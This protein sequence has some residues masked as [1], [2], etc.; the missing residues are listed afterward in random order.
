MLRFLTVACAAATLFIAGCGGGGG[1]TSPGGGSA[2]SGGTPP[3]A[4]AMTQQTCASLATKELQNNPASVTTKWIADGVQKVSSS[5]TSFLPA[6][7]VID[8]TI[9]PRIGVAGVPYGIRF[10]VR[11]PASWNGRFFF[12]GNG[13]FAG[14]LGNVYGTISS[15]NGNNIANT[16]LAQGF[17]VASTDGGH[18]NSKLANGV[19]FGL[20]PQA[21]I[22]YGYNAW[23]KTAVTAKS[24]I[25]AAYG[26]APAKSYFVGCSDGGREGLIFAQRFPT[27]FDGIVG[28]SPVMN[29]GG[30]AVSATFDLQTFK[31]ISPI[32]T[33]GKV[34]QYNSFSASDQA[35]FNTAYMAK[36]DAS[37]GVVDG[38]VQNPLACHF[39][40]SSLQ[41]PGEKT[42]SCLS[43]AQVSAIKAVVNGATTSS[44]DHVTI[45]GY[46]TTHETAVEGYPLDPSWMTSTGQAG[47]LIGTASNPPGPTLGTTALP[48][49]HL[50]PP[51]PDLD[52]MTANWDVIPDQ[53]LVNPPWLATNPDL[54]AFKAHGG[55]LM[56][57]NGTGDPGPQYVNTI[58]YFNQVATL[59]GGVTETKQFFRAFMIPGMAHCSGG[60]S[61]DSF[62]VLAAIMNWVE[63]GQAP[64][65]IVATARAN[66]S[67]LNSV[68][69]PIPAG[70]TRPLCSYPLSA[71]YNGTGD[72]NSASSFSCK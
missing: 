70:R 65:A 25:V 63:K 58:N 4:L 72:I 41:C 8:G 45:P 54:S 10:E 35:L 22:D 59:N 33:D 16:A 1:G 46:L 49:L 51:Q 32:G 18:D 24:A 19:A 31:A 21:D 68:S 55:K 56:L 15:A 20:D 28:G 61:T 62:D 13:G 17:A 11:L 57:Y 39:D 29:L 38:M 52:P 53:M 12:Q 36:C 23:D 5:D 3:L 9:N 6:H 34:Q 43:A 71:V 48:Y 60:P 50:S 7:C 2:D 44:G 37:D 66:N 14:N 64:E 30:Q 42:S 27:Y 26:Q 69:P 67:G 40:V 47:R